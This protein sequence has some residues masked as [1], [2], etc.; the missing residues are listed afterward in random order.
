MGVQAQHLVMYGIKL[1]QEE[2]HARFPSAPDEDDISELVIGDC[3]RTGYR[4]TD[5]DKQHPVMI[6]EDGMGGRYVIL[7][8]II[9]YAN[10]DNG[11]SLNMTQ[12]SAQDDEHHRQRRE[13]IKKLVELGFPV[14][15]LFDGEKPGIGYIVFT[16]HR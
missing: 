5:A 11:E 14:E 10:E 15:E 2:A 1:T 12:L 9:D 6:V 7:G 13:T 16:H 4:I 3:K 8:R